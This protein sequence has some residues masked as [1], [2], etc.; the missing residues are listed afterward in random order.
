[1]QTADGILTVEFDYQGHVMFYRYDDA[2]KLLSKKEIISFPY[3]TD[4][5]VNVCFLIT[6]RNIL[7]IVWK[8]EGGVSV[9]YKYDIAGNKLEKK[10]L[11][12][13][14][15]FRN[16]YADGSKLYFRAVADK[17]RR[18]KDGDEE[19]DEF[20]AVLDTAAWS[21]KRLWSFGYTVQNSN[22]IDKNGEF[23][24][25]FERNVA[26][27]HP[28]AAERSA[29]GWSENALVAR[30]LAPKGALLP[31]YPVWDLPYHSIMGSF[32]YFD[33]SNYLYARH[34]NDVTTIEANGTEH[35][36]RCTSHSV[37]ERTLIWNGRVFADLLFDVTG[38]SAYP[39]SN[40]PLDVEKDG[41]LLKEEYVKE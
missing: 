26:W 35:G 15:G 32:A 16:F 40:E 39:L 38:Y 23:Y 1:M 13:I 3:A 19:D 10:S 33:G 18:D 41:I 4:T 37:A 28:T 27:T 2:L 9:L 31:Q 17:P 11:T 29:N 14:H 6:P 25:D 30:E 12:G 34:S 5:G 24:L 21:L 36:W 7:G 8:D 22:F 20:F